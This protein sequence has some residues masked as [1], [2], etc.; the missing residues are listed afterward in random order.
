MWLSSGL[1]AGSVLNVTSFWL[2]WNV[3]GENPRHTFV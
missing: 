2:T 3:H 1:V